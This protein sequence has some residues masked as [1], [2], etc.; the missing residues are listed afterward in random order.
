MRIELK[1]IRKYFGAVKANDGISLVFEGGKIYGLLGENGAGKSTLMKILSGYQ[2]PDGG[3]ILQ[4]DQAVRFKSPS[5]ALKHGVGMLY[6]DPLDFPPMR[7]LDNYLLGRDARVVPNYGKARNELQ[8]LM[9]RY[10]FTVDI[11]ANIDSLSL[12]E[13]QQL[14]LVRLLAGGAQIL[15]LDEPTTGISAGQKDILFESIRRL[16]HEE[17]K[18]L[19]LVSHK[20]DEV[21]ELCDHA[22]VLRRGKLVG[23]TCIPCPTENL[24]EMMFGQALPR[25]SRPEFKPVYPV[26]ELAPGQE[27]LAGSQ[28]AFEPGKPA[29][30][31][32]DVTLATYRLTVKNIN[33]SIQPGEI[34]GLA[35]L[36]GSGQR[37][38][39]QACA[40][41]LHPEHGKILL[42]GQDVSHWSYHK[43]QAAG[44]SYVAAGRL[45]EGLVA[46]LT[47]T[48]HVV[49]S[50]PEHTFM[51]DWKG[52]EQETGRRIETY[53][54]VGKPELTVDSLSGGNQQRLLFGLLN[55]P[56]KLLL[57]EHP[58]RGLDVR[59]AEYIWD[60]LYRRREDGTAIVF[61]SADLDEI[62]ER[63]DRI[64]VFSGGVMSRIVD[65]RN[66][67][68]DE[69]GHLI[70]GQV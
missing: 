33:L 5:Q 37:L 36:E 64:A 29:V 62:I 4:D 52:A 67:S 54:I 22:F 13:R 60:L 17:G 34:Y 14:E 28:P 50:L 18:T 10:G 55:T 7:V 59:S 27:T 53:Q 61:M 45:E 38:L 40:G 47:L 24:V 58:T 1:E 23:E 68:V 39:V 42:A 25:S 41:L 57:L 48:E 70:G 30:E 56:L 16:T 19:I 35:G 3:Q 2:P 26:A 15:I 21:Q 12:G 69:L 9:E 11:Q 65:A 20:L 6:Q 46:G 43:M 51:V 8:A 44:V 49:L 63:S 31:L 32:Q 66:T